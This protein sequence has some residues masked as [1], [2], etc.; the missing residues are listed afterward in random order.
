MEKLLLRLIT[1]STCELYRLDRG[2]LRFVQSGTLSELYDKRIRICILSPENYVCSETLS[3]SLDFKPSQSTFL[4]GNLSVFEPSQVL[5]LPPEELS[6]NRGWRQVWILRSK[7]DF[8]IE[9]MPSV[10][11]FLP[12]LNFVPPN[13]EG[14]TVS[15]FE[16]NRD[17]Q[18]ARSMQV[19]NGALTVNTRASLDDF[20][21]NEALPGFFI[22]RSHHTR[23][24][25][26]VLAFIVSLGA[27][28]LYIPF[29][30]F[31]QDYGRRSLVPLEVDVPNHFKSFLPS[32]AGTHVT[33]LEI[34]LSRRFVEISFSATPAV[35]EDIIGETV[36]ICGSGRCT[37]EI[38]DGDFERRLVIYEAPIR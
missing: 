24:I 29:Y 38:Y 30:S 1:P 20:I 3:T 5:F 8:L 14:S 10:V 6:G 11:R 13:A 9:K 35:V 32:L 17:E 23:R 31:S 16:V 34:N 33:Q 25:V 37:F 36:E 21:L 12:E 4:F 18:G 2:R 15:D 19:G 28:W 7:L 27:P 26:M 22:G